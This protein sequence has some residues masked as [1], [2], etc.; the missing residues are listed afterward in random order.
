MYFCI[1]VRD[2]LLLMEN[3]A[4]SK[5]GSDKISFISFILLALGDKKL[6]SLT[7]DI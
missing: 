4:I 3:K 6:R 1:P 7:R 5:V 2:E